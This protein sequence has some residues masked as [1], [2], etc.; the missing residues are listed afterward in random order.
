MQGAAQ[1]CPPLPPQLWDMDLPDSTREPDR[2]VCIMLGID[3]I[4]DIEV[5]ALMQSPN[6][7]NR[8]HI[9][10]Y[11]PGMVCNESHYVYAQAYLGL[12]KAGAGHHIRFY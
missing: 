8:N 2:F 7:S 9:P 12:L 4:D 10:W 1:L 6:S 5:P 3:W 11:S